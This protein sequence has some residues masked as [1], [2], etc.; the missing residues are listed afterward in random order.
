MKLFFGHDITNNENKFYENDFAILQASDYLTSSL[1]VWG[2]KVNELNKLSNP[3]FLV[4]SLKSI[5]DSKLNLG[6]LKSTK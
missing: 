6:T 4:I 5:L 3:T 2:D 1:N